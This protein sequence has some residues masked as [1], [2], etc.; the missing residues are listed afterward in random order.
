MGG[1]KREG[2]KKAII[3]FSDIVDL[4]SWNSEAA[5]YWDGEG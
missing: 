4:S 2:G 1:G 5:V 3:I